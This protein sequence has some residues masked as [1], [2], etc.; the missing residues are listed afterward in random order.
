MSDNNYAT[1]QDLADLGAHTKQD[2]ADLRTHVDA[3][4]AQVDARFDQVIEATRDM[5][6]EV[7][8]AFHGWARPTEI[9]LRSHQGWL[10][11]QEER[12]TLLEE[13]L[14]DLERGRI[15]H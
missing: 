7:L 12:L 13:R 11:A 5:Q 3:R 4:F 9:K 14:S 10:A 1:K 2:L 8:R 15:Q 6:T